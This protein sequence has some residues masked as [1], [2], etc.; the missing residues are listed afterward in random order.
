MKITYHYSNGKSF[1]TPCARDLFSNSKSMVTRHDIPADS[2]RMPKTDHSIVEKPAIGITR[3]LTNPRGLFARPKMVVIVNLKEVTID[4]IDIKV[5]QCDSYAHILDNLIDAGWR[6][7]MRK[8][9]N[10][11]TGYNVH[12][13]LTR[14]TY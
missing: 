7:N 13:T 2:S 4:R 5:Y 8:L 14:P 6:V 1:T 11:E 3:V 12:I 10:K 9:H